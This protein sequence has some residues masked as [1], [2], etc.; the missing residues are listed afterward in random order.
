M[1]TSDDQWV[2]TEYVLRIRHLESGHDGEKEIK[3]LLE[4]IESWS[5]DVEAQKNETI[6]TMDEGEV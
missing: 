2:I 5:L 6:W 4:E 1:S 3:E